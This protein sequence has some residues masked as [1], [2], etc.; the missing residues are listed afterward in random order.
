MLDDISSVFENDRVSSI[1]IHK[2]G[3]KAR[4]WS[5]GGFRGRDML[6]EGAGTFDLPS[7][8]DNQVSSIKVFS[9]DEPP[10]S[11]GSGSNPGVPAGIAASFFGASAGRTD[12]AKPE[13][14]NVDIPSSSIPFVARNPEAM[15][16]MNDKL[17][18]VEILKDGIV[19]DLFADSEL[20]G[21]SLRLSS[22][23]KY[24][25]RNYNFDDKT[26][27]VAVTYDGIIPYEPG[28]PANPAPAPA[29]DEY[30]VASVSI[31]SSGELIMTLLNVRTYA[32]IPPL[33][34]ER[35]P[36]NSYL[37]RL[38]DQTTF[39]IDPAGCVAEV[40]TDSLFASGNGAVPFGDDGRK[41]KF[42]PGATLY[43]GDQPSGTLHSLTLWSKPAN[44]GETQP[45]PTPGDG[46]EDP[47]S[48]VETPITP[49]KSDEG[50]GGGD[51]HK[52][53]DVNVGVGG[54]GCRSGAGGL[55]GA[56]LAFFAA[57]KRGKRR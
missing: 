33:S 11:G 7:D 34:W 40:H 24:D 25:L 22:P 14:F 49:P 37:V 16:F 39:W 46:D 19:V 5:D 43:I 8:L 1:T 4:V 52:T 29:G 55:A 2:A 6:Y 51:D 48:G 35:G 10:S 20:S 54:G 42:M 36:D 50:D 31:D 28:Q 41:V 45:A 26:S 17:S 18:C 47:V 12:G 30:E 44:G 9:G 21:E 32:V 56:A 27:S 15:G 23:G 53:L 13:H 38:P 57:V 3:V